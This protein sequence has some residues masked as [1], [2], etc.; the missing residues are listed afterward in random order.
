MDWLANTL[1]SPSLP[2]GG[3]FAPLPCPPPACPPQGAPGPCGP[4]IFSPAGPVT[5][6]R[7][8]ERVELDAPALTRLLT[9]LPPLT[10]NLGPYTQPIFRALPLSLRYRGVIQQLSD[11]AAAAGGAALAAAES[12]GFG[13]DAQPIL[14]PS[15]AP[16]DVV[17]LATHALD[18]NRVGV[19]RAMTIS[20]TSWEGLRAIRVILRASGRQL[21][22][23]RDYSVTGRMP[24]EVPI[25]AELPARSR[26]EVLV[27]N[28]D[29]QSS[30]LV[31]VA[32]DGWTWPV[33]TPD[34]SEQAA[35]LRQDPSL[36]E[37]WG[38][39]RP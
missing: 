9:Q 8:L 37:K 1:R 16:G 38:A 5:D 11:A 39:C 28:L 12:L 33:V 14:V 3:G 24:V 27:R 36:A 30:H 34:D 21:T 32:L 18:V 17:G 13:P 22:E 6:G 23:E 19:L 7:P 10:V 15:A 2:P 20:A 25:Y 4:T 31:E 29:P 35:L 26:L